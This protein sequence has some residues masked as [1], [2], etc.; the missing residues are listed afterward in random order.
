VTGTLRFGTVTRQ[1][2]N[3]WGTGYGVGVQSWTTYLRT[4]GNFAFYKGGSHSDEPLNAG[5][6]TALATLASDGTLTLGGRLVSR[7]GREIRTASNSLSLT[8]TNWTALNDM[9]LKITTTGNPVLVMFK[10]GGVQS[11]GGTQSGQFRLLVAGV[12]VAYTK[13]E[14]HNDGW[15]LRDVSLTWLAT[16]LPAGTHEV[17]VEWA[18]SNRL[19]CCLY[20]DTRHLIAVEL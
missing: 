13:H 8:A 5:G 2:L 3:L 12:Q 16:N 17:K 20:N 14:F 7:A 6:G 15:E 18:A 4:D 19:L 1:M 9:N 11:S 10:T